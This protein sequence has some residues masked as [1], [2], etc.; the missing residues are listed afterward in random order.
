M[1]QSGF[2]DQVSRRMAAL[3]PA[4]R[5]VAEHLLAAGPGRRA[6]L[7]RRDRRAARHERRHRRPHGQG[8]G[9]RRARRTAARDRGAGRRPATR[10]TPSSDARGDAARRAAH[11]VYHPPSCRRG[12]AGPVGP[13]S[14]VPAGRRRLVG[15]RARRL[16]R[17]GAVGSSRSLRTTLVP[18]H[19]T[20]EPGDG[21][22]RRV[23]R[24]R[25]SRA[26]IR[27][28][29][30]RHGVRPLAVARLG[31]AR[32][33]R[34]AG[35]P[36]RLD[37]RRSRAHPRYTGCVAPAMWPRRCPGS[38][39][40]TR[41]PSC[42]SR[43]SCSRSR[44]RTKHARNRHSCRSTNCARRSPLPRGRDLTAV[45]TPR[46]C[47]ARTDRP[48]PSP[49]PRLEL[50][51][52]RRCSRLVPGASLALRHARRPRARLSLVRACYGPVSELESVSA[53]EPASP[54]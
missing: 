20:P 8:V 6:P 47:T 52:I 35:V 49:S 31:S 5:R 33:R 7:G 22:D 19:R 42:W 46:T 28:R 11:G 1:L 29:G 14:G 26:P 12:H 37:H 54:C 17:R 36:R 10:A 3:T 2:V 13:T 4:E 45:N 27:R 25:A 53:S 32:S 41:E 39:A 24:R 21:R 50:A 18:P 16:A 38:S 15:E 30:R 51:S 40:A 43:H 44:R 34:H 48:K 23:V 9:I